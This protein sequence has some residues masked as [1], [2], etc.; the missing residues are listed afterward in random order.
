MNCRRAFALTLAL[1]DTVLMIGLCGAGAPDALNRAACCG[2][3]VQAETGPLL[4]GDVNC[5]GGVDINDALLILRSVAGLPVSADCLQQNGD[6]DCNGTVDSADALQ[7]LR[8]LA[9]KPVT[10]PAGCPPLGGSEQT[11]ADKIE[12]ALKA[13]KIDSETALVYKVFSSFADSRLPTEYKGDDTYAEDNFLLPELIVRLPGLSPSNQAILRPFLRTPRASDGWFQL[14]AAESATGT[15]VAAAGTPLVFLSVDSSSHVRVWYQ[16]RHPED[17]AVAQGIANEVDGVIWPKLTGLLG[18]PLSDAGRDDNG[19]DGRVDIYLAE[20]DVR[21]CASPYSP[22]CQ[23]AP[24]FVVLRRNASKSTLAHELTHVVLFSYR[25]KTE[26]QWEEYA[27]LQEA[28]AQWIMDYVYPSINE[29]R[30]GRECFLSSPGL[31]LEYRNNCREYDA[32]LWD[33]FLARNFQPELI[34]DTWLKA[35]QNDS[36]GAIN[37]AL[38]GLG[39]FKEVWPEFVIDNYNLTPLDLYRQWDGVP[40]GAKFE[41][42]NVDLGGSASKTYE[43]RGDVEHLAALYHRFSFNDPNIKS[44]RFTHPF[45]DGSQPT[46]K[47]QAIVKIVGQDWKIEDWTTPAHREFCFSKPEEKLEQ[48]LI[49]ISNSE[50]QN[51]SH[52]L[53][54]IPQPTLEVSTLGCSRWVGTFKSTYSQN[55][56][57]GTITES[58]TATVTFELDPNLIM[59]PLPPRYWMSTSGTVTWSH[60]GTVF[61]CSGNTSGSYQLGLRD[62]TLEIWDDGGERLRYI[63][64]GQTPPGMNITVP[65]TCPDAGTFS[66]ILGDGAVHHWFGTDLDE[67]FRLQPDGSIK[68]TRT[69][70]D[71]L[72]LSTQTWEWEIHPQ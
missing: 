57:M 17:Q 41:E 59:P 44:V 45:A 6:V 11:S 18:L 70:T 51:R 16:E 39:G 22:A 56:V 46:A 10:L 14:R 65:Y 13:G 20:P 24:A 38:A 15:F 69:F 32:Y 19:E 64:L 63:G 62:A 35:N 68:D 30:L 31:P 12:E 55:S 71:P 1:I 21:S 25:V 53:M 23:Q 61:N 58:A 48:L 9:G 29:E 8:H 60:K 3:T 26:C 4:K 52:V 66:F 28:T 47:V 43:V 67:V 72:G 50:Y 2:P 49:V 34:R 37:A 27:W 42:T 7:I 54:S 40:D 36:L 33:F 5:S